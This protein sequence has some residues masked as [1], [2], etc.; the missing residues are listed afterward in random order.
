MTLVSAYKIFML[1]FYKQLYLISRMKLIFRLKINN[2]KSAA[3]AKSAVAFFY[4]EF[5]YLPLK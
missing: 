5:R 3:S 1:I 2:K 4:P